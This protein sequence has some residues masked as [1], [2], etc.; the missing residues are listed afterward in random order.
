M[1]TVII[2]YLYDVSMLTEKCNKNNK[3]LTDRILTEP[4]GAMTTIH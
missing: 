3:F 1:T 2:D 4:I